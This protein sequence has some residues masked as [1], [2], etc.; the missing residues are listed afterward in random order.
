MFA[1]L[2]DILLGKIYKQKSNEWKYI[3]FLRIPKLL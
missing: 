2:K 1:Y 3:I